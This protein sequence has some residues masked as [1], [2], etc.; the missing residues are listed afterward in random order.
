MFPS[1]KEIS[2][3]KPKRELTAVTDFHRFEGD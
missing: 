3:N 1:E 2:E